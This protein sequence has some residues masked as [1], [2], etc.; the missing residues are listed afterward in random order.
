MIKSSKRWSLSSFAPYNHLNCTN[1]KRARERKKRKKSKYI[2]III[3]IGEL[4]REIVLFF[5]I[6]YRVMNKY[7]FISLSYIY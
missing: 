4:K 3:I 1:R 6:E 7:M 2:N 5:S